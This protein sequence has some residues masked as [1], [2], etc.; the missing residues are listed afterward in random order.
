MIFERYCDISLVGKTGKDERLPQF[1]KC[2]E[3][4]VSE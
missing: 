4:L 1:L 2:G 3:K